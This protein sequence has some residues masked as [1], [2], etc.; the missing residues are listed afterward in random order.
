MSH[1]QRRPRCDEPEV[2]TNRWAIKLEKA[3]GETGYYCCVGADG[4]V[5]HK[6]LGGSVMW[7]DSRKDAERSIRWLC[8]HFDLDKEEAKPEPWVF[9]RTYGVWL[10]GK[11]WP[12]GFAVER[13]EE[14]GSRYLLMREDGQETSHEIP[15][16]VADLMI[17]LLKVLK[18]RLPATE[19]HTQ[20]PGEDE[21]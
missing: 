7:F 1:R 10:K 6:E 17:R 8:K 12:D 18:K 2:H 14:T 9:E 16:E 20:A 11:E 13:D 3:T 19:L 21:P 15:D 5:V 4:I